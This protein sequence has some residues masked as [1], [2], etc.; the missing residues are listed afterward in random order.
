M[1]PNQQNKNRLESGSITLL[2]MLLLFCFLFFYEIGIPRQEED[3]GILV[4][5]GNVDMAGGSSNMA[6]SMPV[7]PEVPQP[8]PQPSEP[9]PSNND[10]MT[11]EDESVEVQQERERKEKERHEKEQLERERKEK[12]AREKAEREARERAEAEKRRQEQEAINKAQQIGSLFGQGQGES[13]QGTSR[14]GSGTNAGQGQQGNPV[15]QGVSNGTGWSLKGRSL[16]GTLQ[17]PQYDVNEEGKI[18]VEIWVDKEGN[19][20]VADIAAQGSTISNKDL[21]QAAINVALKAKFTKGEAQKQQG[22]LTY[23]FKLK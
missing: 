20:I 8:Q 11:Q 7:V 13:N 10:L 14:E 19:V 16:K 21:R 6:Q 18:V 5:F 2:L 22:F 12:E 15:G 3:E 4:S 23:Y 1:T 17:K 9:A